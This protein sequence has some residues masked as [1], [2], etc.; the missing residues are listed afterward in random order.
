MNT[1]YLLTLFT[2]C[3]DR[4]IFNVL[5]YNKSDYI[6]LGDI[7]VSFR[8]LEVCVILDVITPWFIRGRDLIH[9]TFCCQKYFTF[10]D[11]VIPS[12]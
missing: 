9:L 2:A 3:L 6:G 11:F 4:T 12:I 7:L 8:K 5:I 1:L 10:L